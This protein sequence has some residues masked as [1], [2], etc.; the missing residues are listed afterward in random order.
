MPS[1]DEDVWSNEILDDDDEATIK[2]KQ[3]LSRAESELERTNE[4]LSKNKKKSKKKKHKKKRLRHKAEPLESTILQF[5]TQNA[6]DWCTFA[7]CRDANTQQNC[8]CRSYVYF[9]WE[10]IHLE[11]FFDAGTGCYKDWTQSGIC[12][13]FRCG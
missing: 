2:L 11:A 5:F 12:I 8:S 7:L 4:E 1:Y 9:A 10:Q 3:R 6:V 13:T